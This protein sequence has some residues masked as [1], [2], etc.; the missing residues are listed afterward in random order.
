DWAKW[1]RLLE[2]AYNSHVSA[3]TGETPFYL[4]LGYHPPSPLD[5]HYPSAKQEEDRYGLD[6]QGR[7]FVRD[8]RVHRESARRAIAKAQDA[9]KRAY[10]KG[11]RD[12]SEIQ[13]GSWVLI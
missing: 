1:S 3:T 4:L 11:R 7:V 5:L 6:K 10:D 13:E 8:L 12:T 9:Q 2:F